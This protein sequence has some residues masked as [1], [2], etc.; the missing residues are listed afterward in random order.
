MWI[1]R[2]SEE[3]ASTSVENY[4]KKSRLSRVRTSLKYLRATEFGSFKSP[5]QSSN[6]SS[7]FGEVLKQL[8]KKQINSQI[9]K[10]TGEYEVPNALS[11]SLHHV[12]IGFV[13][14]GGSSVDGFLNYL[15]QNNNDTICLEIERQT[16][17]QHKCELWHELRY[18]RI[19][20][21]KAFEVLRC[22]TLDGTLVETILGAYKVP[23]TKAMQ[24]GRELEGKVLVEVKKR[25][26]IN[27]A[28]CGL[29]ICQDYP[30]IS[31]S[32]DGIGE[33]FVVEV[34]CPTST[35]TY[36]TYITDAGEISAKCNAQ[37]QLQMYASK[38]SYCLF[39]LAYPK[40]EENKEVNIICI[41]Y[42]E[43]Y[44]NELLVRL[45]EFWTKC[46]FP[47]IYNSVKPI[48]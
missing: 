15:K 12:M 42:D 4:W 35:N 18:G 1:H 17:R 28:N 39:C 31:A 45:E 32:P 23:D 29:L 48:L 37:V 41:Q 11:L 30:F 36:K 40:F 21:S 22:K 9:I 2:R 3:P 47:K 14:N 19:T 27:I 26:D 46:I 10:H 33:N 24:R 5:K 6:V 13:K 44:V 7:L 25:L 16:K 43:K 8:N 34:K 20:A 38:T